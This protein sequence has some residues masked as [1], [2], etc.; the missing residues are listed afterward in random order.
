VPEAGVV[1][2]D[3]VVAVAER[4]DQ[5][6]ELVRSGREA[7]EQK[8]RSAAR[9]T[10]LAVEDLDAVHVQESVGNGREIRGHLLNIGGF[11]CPDLLRMTPTGA[12][13][14]RILQPPRAPFA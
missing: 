9:R 3:Q 1:G 8:Q 4:V 11:D 7:V 13:G 6:A 10:G 12:P 5:P 2:R 14:P